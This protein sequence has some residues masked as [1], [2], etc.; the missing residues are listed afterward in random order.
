MIKSEN[1]SFLIISFKEVKEMEEKKGRKRKQFDDDDDDEVN[2]AEEASAFR[3]KLK[4]KQ[5][6]TQNGRKK[7]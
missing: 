1:L 7:F 6:G 2:D 5:K 4:R 3:K